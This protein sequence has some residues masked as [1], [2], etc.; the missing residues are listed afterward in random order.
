MYHWKIESVVLTDPD[1]SRFIAEIL[2]NKKII[3]HIEK[4]NKNQES[5]TVLY[6]EAVAI[7]KDILEQAIQH[8]RVNLLEFL[9]ET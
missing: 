5:K 2:I 4:E 7:P 6:E 9:E 8:A 3:G 1:F